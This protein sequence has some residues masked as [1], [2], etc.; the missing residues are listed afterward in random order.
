MNNNDVVFNA[1][2]ALVSLF[3]DQIK[4]GNR[5][6]HSRI[7]NYILHPE[8]KYVL[9]GMSSTVAAGEAPYPEHVVPCAVLIRETMRLIDENVLSDDQ[10]ARL[11]QQHW[12]IVTIS[13]SEAKYLDST[14]RLKSRMP[15][16]WRFEDGDT[17]LRLK[18]AKITVK[19][20]ANN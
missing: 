6:V 20:S 10:I 15:E 19:P 1:C 17:F 3:R 5:C 9:W 16:G 7:F 4:S 14:L 11:I 12:K 8:S 13:K 2:K 18:L